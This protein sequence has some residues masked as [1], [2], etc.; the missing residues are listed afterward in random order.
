MHVPGG[1][2]LV[3]LVAIG[4]GGFGVYQLYRAARAKLGKQLSQG[5]ARADVGSWVIWV[6]RVGIAARGLVFMA[7][8]WL[9]GRAAASHDPSRAGGIGDALASLAQLGRFPY[10]AIGGGLMAY[11]VYQLLN[12]RYRRMSP[13]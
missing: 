9:L 3:W 12:A 11:G 13:A 4:I 2:W 7:I 1:N 5:E 6:S 8:A 10:A